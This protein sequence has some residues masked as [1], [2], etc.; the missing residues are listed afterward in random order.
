M[1]Y[2]IQK[3]L[4]LLP[5][6]HCKDKLVLY[7]LKPGDIAD[8]TNAHLFLQHQIFFLDIL[9]Q[10]GKRQSPLVPLIQFPAV[11]IRRMLIFS[12][13]FIDI[14]CLNLAQIHLP[15]LLY[16]DLMILS[17]NSSQFLPHL[18]LKFLIGYCSC[19]VILPFNFPC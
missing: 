6:Y 3:L 9:C 14:E 2:L 8:E 19:H 1:R 5:A 12:V 17:K 11:K 4:V 16:T 13:L 15:D 7:F 10:N 18:F